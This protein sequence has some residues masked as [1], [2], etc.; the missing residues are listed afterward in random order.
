MQ[1]ACD[2]DGN[3]T[4][5][6][7]ADKGKE[8]ICPV[9]GKRVILKQG[10]INIPHFAHTANECEDR[11]HYDMSEWHFAM[12]NRFPAECR[13]VVVKHNG[14]THRADILS[15]NMV[16]EFQH[17]PISQE[18]LLERNNFYQSAGYN[19]AWVF[20]LQEQY[21]DCSIQYMDSD[22]LMLQWRYPKRFLQCLPVPK[23]GNKDLV[24]F[25]YWVDSDDC[26]WFFRV[27]WSTKDDDMPNFKRFIVS[28]RSMY[29]NDGENN[30][31]EVK[32]FFRTHDDMLK[33]CLAQKNVKY[34]IKRKGIKGYPRTD[35][36][37]P[38]TGV[39]GLQN[40]GE[41]SCRYCRYCCAIK[42][43]RDDKFSAYCS[44]PVQVN[45]VTETHEG[46][47]CSGIPTF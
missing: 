3:R 28:D 34:S 2:K 42:E 19:I 7:N 33:E 10:S 22:A 24:L 14:A 30:A 35:Y 17:S 47:E 36:I 31:L 45:E 4:L 41:K 27:I 20:D 13:E 26:E 38:R 8:Y 46:Y 39:F 15:G 9:C 32:W 6:D 18:E 16:I 40:Y 5:A 23:E 12:Q 37:C 11:W 43:Y 44:Y 21:D 1:F 29:F 25:F